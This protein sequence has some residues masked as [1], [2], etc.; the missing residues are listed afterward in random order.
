MAYS[1]HIT[2]TT[3]PEMNKMFLEFLSEES[4]YV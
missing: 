4:V 2:A 1:L 3:D